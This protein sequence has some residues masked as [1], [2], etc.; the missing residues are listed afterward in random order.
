MAKWKIRILAIVFFSMI[1][2]VGYY[3]KDV[4]NVEN[5]VDT[6]DEAGDRDAEELLIEVGVPDDELS[7]MQKVL[8]NKGEYNDGENIADVEG[9]Y[10]DEFERTVKF[11]AVDLDHDGEDEICLTYASGSVLIFHEIDGHIYGYDYAWRGFTPVY[12]DGTFWGSGGASY[13]EFYGNV[14]FT[15]EEFYKKVITAVEYLDD[16]G[17]IVYYKNGGSDTGITISKEEY[18]QIMSKYE[19]V[20][21][22]E[23]DFTI[24]NVLKYVK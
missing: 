16:A 17:T 24:D 21:V 19:M 15:K 9:I 10:N 8:F 23:Y 7:L 5:Q 12:E 14:S 20:K 1:L 4:S 22:E 3:F 13:S 2:V 11:C 6:E 18:D